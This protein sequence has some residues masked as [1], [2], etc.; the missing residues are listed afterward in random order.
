MAT[1]AS[2]VSDALS[3]TVRKTASETVSSTQDSCALCWAIAASAGAL[4]GS[5]RI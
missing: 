2:P 1:L 3:P 5:R 4:Y